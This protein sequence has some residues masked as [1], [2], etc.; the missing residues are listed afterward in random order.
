MPHV[1]YSLIVDGCIESG[2]DFTSGGAIY[3]QTSPLAAGPITASDSLAAVKKVVFDDGLLS[4]EELLRVLDSNFA[5][6]SGEEIRQMLIKP[7][8]KVRQ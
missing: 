6:E 1:F 4:M 8:A 7:G 2:K 3:N 5:G